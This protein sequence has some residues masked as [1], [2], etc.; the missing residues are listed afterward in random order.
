MWRLL[1]YRRAGIVFAAGAVINDF[2]MVSDAI[3]MKYD[4]WVGFNSTILEGVKISKGVFIA[5]CSAVTITKD[6]PKFCIAAGNPAKV[7][8]HIEKDNI[9]LSSPIM[10]K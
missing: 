2:D 4:V 9:F 1:D 3:S 8:K 6:V 5:A 7:I 10:N